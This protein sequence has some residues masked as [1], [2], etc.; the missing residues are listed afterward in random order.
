MIDSGKERVETAIKIQ[1]AC[2]FL[3]LLGM[4]ITVSSTG[5]MLIEVNP[6]ANL[7]FQERTAG[8][9]LKDKRARDEFEKYD[10]FINRHQ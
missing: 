4:D 1:E 3:K 2:P 10:L 5:P 7:V 6:S 8:P 9:L